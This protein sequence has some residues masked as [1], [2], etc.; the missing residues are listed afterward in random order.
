MEVGSFAYKNGKSDYAGKVGVIETCNKCCKGK[1]RVQFIGIGN[2]EP[3]ENFNLGY[4]TLFIAGD[5]TK[6]HAVVFTPDAK[7]KK[8]FSNLGKKSWEKRKKALL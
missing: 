3:L 1:L 6:P 8:H 2:N 5:T 7:I 4:C